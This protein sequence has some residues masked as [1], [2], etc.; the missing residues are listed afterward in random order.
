MATQRRIRFIYYQLTW[1]IATILIL[2]TLSSFSY[3]TFFVLSL[4][5]LLITTELTAP[6][7]VTPKWRT[8]LRWII[9]VGLIWFGYFVIRRTL[10][11]LP[12]EI[13]P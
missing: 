3:E 12:P 8:R 4:I 9:L 11:I 2:S 10:D 7:N 1:M 5:G 13:L 6:A